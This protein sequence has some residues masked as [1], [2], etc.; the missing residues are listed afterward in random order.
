MAKDYWDPNTY[1]LENQIL[2]M[3]GGR[4]VVTD[5]DGT[6]MKGTSDHVDVYWPSNSDKGHGHGGVDYDDEGNITNAE[7]YHN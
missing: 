1:T 3:M 5:D 6:V 4:D 7:V 2:D